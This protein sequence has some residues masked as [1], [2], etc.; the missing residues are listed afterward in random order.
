M[1]K[2]SGKSVP[3]CRKRLWRGDNQSGHKCADGN[4]RRRGEIMTD[5]IKQLKGGKFLN[6]YVIKAKLK[7]LTP[8]HL[9]EGLTREPEGMV[10]EKKNN[11]KLK[12]NTVV[13]DGNGKAYIPGSSL[14]GALRDWLRLGYDGM[15]ENTVSYTHLTLPTKRIV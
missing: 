15:T 5:E 13:T 7:A 8:F 6:R 1:A 4:G 12:C 9:G 2:M 3:T 14:R 10:D 11:K